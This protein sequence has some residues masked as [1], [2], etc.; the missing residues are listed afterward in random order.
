MLL[1]IRPKV[2]PRVLSTTN[3]RLSAALP[4]AVSSPCPRRSITGPSQPPAATDWQKESLSIIVSDADWADRDAIIAGAAGLID[5]SAGPRRWELTSDRKG[6]Q[7]VVRFKGFGQCWR[8]LGLYE[9][10]GGRG[11]APETSSGVDEYL[12]QGFCAV[13]DA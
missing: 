11:E 8:A 9:R 5:D 1:R 3:P 12:Q 2:S 7:R 13:D 6:V 10:R 4:H